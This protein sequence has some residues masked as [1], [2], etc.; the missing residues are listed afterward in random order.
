MISD[1][2]HAARD[3][4]PTLAPPCASPGLGRTRPN[5]DEQVILSPAPRPVMRERQRA[6]H[7]SACLRASSSRTATTTGSFTHDAALPLHLPKYRL[8]AA[9]PA[10]TVTVLVLRRPRLPALHGQANSRAC[11]AAAIAFLPRAPRAGRLAVF[12]LRKHKHKVTPPASLLHPPCC[13]SLS[14]VTRCPR[15]LATPSC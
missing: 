8:T 14:P 3:Q 11:H 15:L 6:C 1:S 2:L 4:K 9:I 12:R 5:D 10:P 13:Q 7:G